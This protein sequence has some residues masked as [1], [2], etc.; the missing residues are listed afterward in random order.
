MTDKKLTEVQAA[1]RIAKLLA[2]FTPEQRKR[3]LDFVG[4]Q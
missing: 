3:I 4:A 1:A 2:Q